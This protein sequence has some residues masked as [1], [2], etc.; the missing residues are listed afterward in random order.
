MQGGAQESTDQELFDTWVMGSSMK[1][2][3]IPEMALVSVL[4][5]QS[6]LGRIQ[7]RCKRRPSSIGQRSIKRLSG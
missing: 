1:L 5:V 3:F 6:S 7:L 2:V 4:T